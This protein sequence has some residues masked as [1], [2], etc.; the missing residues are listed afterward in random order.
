MRT[1][2]DNSGNRSSRRRFLTGASAASLLGLAG[3]AKAEPLP[4]IRKIRLLSDSVI[5]LAPQFLAEELLRLEG[6]SE[7]EYVRSGAGE[8]GINLLG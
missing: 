8:L 2:S 6:F 7:V 3:P 4:E 5:C 1:A